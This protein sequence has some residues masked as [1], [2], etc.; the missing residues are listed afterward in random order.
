MDLLLYLLQ[1]KHQVVFN[2]EGVE[3]K[4]PEAGMSESV[5]K[6]ALLSPEIKTDSEVIFFVCGCFTDRGRQGHKQCP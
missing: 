5:N 4:P 3:P 1:I 2:S 6:A